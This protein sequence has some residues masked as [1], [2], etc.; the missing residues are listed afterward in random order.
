MISRRLFLVVL[1]EKFEFEPK[2]IF[3]YHKA[4]RFGLVP[5][6]FPKGRERQMNPK[7]VERTQ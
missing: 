4:K 6:C 3:S 7:S 1:V 2:L 5:E